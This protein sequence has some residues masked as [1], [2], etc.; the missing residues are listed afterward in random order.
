MLV[1]MPALKVLVGPDHV[2]DLAAH[3]GLQDLGSYSGVVRHGHDFSDVVAERSDDHLVV[4]ART[5]GARGRLQAVCQLVNCE[6]VGYP[7]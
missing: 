1:V 7:R 2:C 5:L 6:P 4:G 3:I